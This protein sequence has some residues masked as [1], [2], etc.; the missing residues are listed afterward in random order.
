VATQPNAH[1]D[2]SGK[3]NVIFHGAFTFVQDPEKKHIL[4]EMPAIEDHVYRAGTWLAE[5]EIRG[6]GIVYELNEQGVKPGKD[7]LDPKKNLI[8]KFDRKAPKPAPFATL[9][10]PFPEKIH[11]LRISEVDAK[12]FK[13][14]TERVLNQAKQPMALLQVFTYVIA[15]VDDLFIGANLD[16]GHYWEPAFTE[17]QGSHVNLHVF[18]AED[19][20]HK[21]SN[22]QEDFNKCMELL[23]VELRLQTKYLPAGPIP[24]NG[25]LP[26]GVA[27]EET[28]D[29]GV[30][31]LRMARL[32]RAKVQGGDTNVAWFGNDALD[33]NIRACTGGGGTDGTY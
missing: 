24:A 29:L 20:Y 2:A 25:H 17:N 18:S 13:G 8:V 28:E 27:P 22:V 3:L 1:P 9:K 30:R 5:T 12:F 26:P 10:L 6:G 4:A 19:H 33:G 23:A 16:E 31:T 14:K 11:S 32:G 15:N 7:W 21:P